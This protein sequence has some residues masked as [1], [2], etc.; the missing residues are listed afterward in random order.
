MVS[1][2]E[3]LTLLKYG[4]K[5]NRIK[6]AVDILIW[7]DQLQ[8]QFVVWFMIEIMISWGMSHSNKEIVK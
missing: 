2:K 4:W 1:R 5:P 7:M 3:K 8:L 6:D